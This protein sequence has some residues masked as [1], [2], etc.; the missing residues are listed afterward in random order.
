MTRAMTALRADPLPAIEHRAGGARAATHQRRVRRLL[1]LGCAILAIDCL[2]WGVFFALRGDWLT[3]A[4]DGGLVALA[5]GTAAM[6]RAGHTR[7]ASRLLIAVLYAVLCFN[8]AVLDVPSAAVPRSMHQ[9]LLALGIVSCL[10]TRDEPAWLRHGIPLVC[11]ATYL[12]F[13]SSNAGWVTSLALPDAVRA[14]GAWVNNGIA[15]VVVFATLHIIQSDVSV[16]NAM[17]V[18]LRDALL[19]DQFTLYYQPQVDADHRVTGAEALLRWTH[20]TRGMV[21][22][23][24]FIPV[25]E[26]SGLMPPLGDWVLRTACRQLVAWSL[27]PQTAALTLAVNVSVAQFAQPDFVTRVLNALRETGA[28]PARLKLELTESMLAHD[29]ED[30]IGKMT[31]LKAHGIAFSLDDFGTGFSSLAYLRRLPLD[32]LKIDQLFVRDM[33]TSPNGAGIARAVVTLGHTLGLEVIAEGVETMAQRDFLAG[34]GCH[35]YQGY[36]FGKPMQAAEFERLAMRAP[37]QSS[38]AQQAQREPVRA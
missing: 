30:V 24:K 35:R 34:L 19:N 26:Q 20:P 17:E 2:G 21:P 18:E 7:N 22:P 14:G 1:L 12:G 15:L 32:Q 11:L 3:A 16:R 8:A 13:A 33:M 31:Q 38:E 10:L 6:V 28:D 36:L 9:Y 23:G 25:A 4:L 5:A 29:L 27:Q 37:D